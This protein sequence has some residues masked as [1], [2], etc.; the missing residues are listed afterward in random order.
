MGL[1]SNPAARLCEDKIGIIA[2][3]SLATRSEYAPTLKMHDDCR[4]PDRRSEPVNKAG[5]A[6]LLTLLDFY[7]IFLTCIQLT[8]AGL[9][10]HLP[11][12]ASLWR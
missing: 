3:A 12:L 10:S 8:R 11:S 7:E 1:S 6:F 9:G 2:V 5:L 4:P